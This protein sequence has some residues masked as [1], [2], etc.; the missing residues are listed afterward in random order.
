LGGFCIDSVPICEGM[1]AAETPASEK[2][3]ANDFI[4]SFERGHWG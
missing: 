1:G 2:E 3:I 4:H